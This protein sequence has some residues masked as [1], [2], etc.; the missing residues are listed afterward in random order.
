MKLAQENAES[1]RKD[2][3]TEVQQKKAMENVLQLEAGKREALVRQ[4]EG[5]KASVMAQLHQLRKSHEL[6]MGEQSRQI[7]QVPRPDKRCG[8]RRRGCL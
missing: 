3:A 1:A 2:A 8:L 5:E 4:L 7:D 6:E